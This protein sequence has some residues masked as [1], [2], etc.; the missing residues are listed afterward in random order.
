MMMVMDIHMVTLLQQV[1]LHKLQLI[2]MEQQLLRQ[3]QLQVHL[4]VEITLIH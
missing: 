3:R 2:Q 4:Q 1:L